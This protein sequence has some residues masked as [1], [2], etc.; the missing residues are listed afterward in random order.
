MH[1]VLLARPSTTAQTD[2]GGIS[3]SGYFIH[4]AASVMSD[5]QVGKCPTA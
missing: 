1:G 2:S 4:D 5:V 3:S